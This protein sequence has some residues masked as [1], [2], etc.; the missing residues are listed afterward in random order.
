MT[1]LKRIG[2]ELQR[3]I[4]SISFP[5]AVRMCRSAEEI[6]EK[7]RTPDSLGYRVAV[8]QAIG[9][10]RRYGWTVAVGREN[11]GCVF[12][13]IALGFL[14][15]KSFYL[16]G[17][18]Y[19]D[20]LP[21]S[22]EGAATTAQAMPKLT[23][24]EY[25]YVVAAPLDR[26]AFEPQ[27]IV[28]YGN[29]AQVMRMVQGAI[30]KRGGFLDFTTAGMVDCSEV[31]SKTLL[32]GQCQVV[33]PGAGD[34]VWGLAQDDEMAFTIPLGEVE[35]IIQGLEG[36]HAFGWRIPTPLFS[37][38]QPQFPPHVQEFRAKLERDD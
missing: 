24:G 33:L 5:V 13:S 19:R 14:P 3:Y 7:A 38:I 28:V 8:C 20:G 6:P 29:S 2:E 26:A 32:T 22:R 36:T 18:Y 15:A 9:M 11:H 10:A 27:F 34:R 12:G 35:R 21:G 25:S 1:E 16:D 31:V 23:Y 17:S 30:Y 37:R 4:R